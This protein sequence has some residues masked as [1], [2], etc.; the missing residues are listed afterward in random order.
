MSAVMSERDF[1]RQVLD[2]DYRRGCMEG[3]VRVEAERT[4][5]LEAELDR[6]IEKRAAERRDANRIEE[7]WKDSTRL[8]NERR[9]KENGA[10]WYAHHL[11]MHE[12]HARLAEEHE[13][14]A[15]S[16]LQAGGDTT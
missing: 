7:L 11:R 2:L 12:V 4:E 3:S 1:E 16:L 14:A 13:N 9:R 15:L 6:I 8:H 5:K 10:A